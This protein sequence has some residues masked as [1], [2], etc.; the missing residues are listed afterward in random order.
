[1]I[2]P[3]DLKEFVI[4]PSL[5]A[6]DDLWRGAFSEAAVNLLVGTA[7]HES[8]VAGITHLKQIRGPAL[9]IYQIEPATHQDNW[10]NYL[11][12]R[13]SKASFVRSLLSQKMPETL[14][15]FHGHLIHNLVYATVQ[16]RLV[17][18]RQDFDS[19]GVAWPEDP[20]DIETLA[21]I[22]DLCYNKNPE[23][24]FPEDFVRDY[25]HS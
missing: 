4:V 5:R 1:M 7:A 17:Y 12:L 20:E 3:N 15:E 11:D 13:D 6:M 10:E 16:A 24:G 23:K 25:P 2:D 9:G 21:L 18:W 8:T 19:K 22:W 14:E